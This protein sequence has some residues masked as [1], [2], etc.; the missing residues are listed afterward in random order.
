M[1]TRRTLR[2]SYRYSL[3][4]AAICTA[5]TRI[6]SPDP[7]ARHTLWL[8]LLTSETESAADFVKLHD[9]S[10]SQINRAMVNDRLLE[11]PAFIY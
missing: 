3:R 7:N 6:K 5:S 1:T 10:E 8:R 2:V 9:V 4:Q 11:S